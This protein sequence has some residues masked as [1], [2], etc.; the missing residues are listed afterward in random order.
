MPH[1]LRTFALL[2]LATALT[3]CA[4]HTEPV[5]A[6]SQLDPDQ[7]QFEALW[8][9]SQQ[10]LRACDW[11]IVRTDRRDGLVLTE[12]MVGEHWFEFWRC[13]AATA[14]DL[15]ESTV[16]TIYRQV[17]VQIAP[18]EGANT[19]TPVVTVRTFRSDR[20]SY[21][22]TSPVNAYRVLAIPGQERI[23]PERL[24]EQQ[25]PRARQRMMPLGNDEKLAAK[26]QKKISEKAAEIQ[27]QLARR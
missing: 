21:Q 7:R 27:Q 16:Q 17:E 13:D 15:V 2:A 12:P 23:E 5:V 3:G 18:D 11:T 9:A 25:G 6:G 10:V 8:Q 26:L 4:R 20:P 22:A 19:F 14:N 1:K 24:Y